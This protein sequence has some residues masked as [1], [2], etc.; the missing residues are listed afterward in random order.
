MIPRGQQRTRGFDTD[1]RGASA[2]E[3]AIL[4]PIFLIMIFGMIAYAIYFGAAHSVQQIAADAARASVAG[5]DGPE[6]NALVST[7]ISNNGGGYVLLDPDALTFTVGDKSGDASQYEVTVSY[8]ASSLPIWGLQ[9][10][11]PLPSSTIRHVYSIR[12]G[13]L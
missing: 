6:R 11:L 4:A 7:Y 9:P 13:G 10:W 5:L 8:D 2:V 3:F 12:K 1:D